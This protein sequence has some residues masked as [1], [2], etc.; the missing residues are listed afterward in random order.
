MV[1]GDDQAALAEYNRSIDGV[2]AKYLKQ[3]NIYYQKIGNHT[4]SP[5]FKFSDAQNRGIF[6]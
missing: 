1:V 6:A 5:Q 3:L 2:G 4:I